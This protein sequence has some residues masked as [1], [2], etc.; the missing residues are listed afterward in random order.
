MKVLE[1]L[2]ADE[3]RR[4]AVR[5]LELDGKRPRSNCTCRIS[6]AA[7]GDRSAIVAG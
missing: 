4:M 2:I 7:G 6:S 3:Q 1:R 5:Q